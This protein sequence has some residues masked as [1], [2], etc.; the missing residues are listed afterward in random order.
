[1]KKTLVNLLKFAV[2]AGI[3]AWLFYKARQDEHF[4]ELVTGPK[5]WGL[6]LAAAFVAL[7]AVLGTILRWYFLVRALELPFTVKD[8][9]RLGFLGYLL[10]FVSV[11]SVGGDLF[12]AVFVAREHPGRRAEAVATVAIDRIIGLYVMFVLASASLLITGQLQSAGRDVQIIGRTTLLA[13]LAGTVGVVVVLLPGMTNGRFSHW[14]GRIPKVGPIVVRLMGAVRMYRRKLPVLL[15][16]AVI[17]VAVHSL[18]AVAIFLVAR[19]L[20]GNAPTLAEHFVAVPLANLTGLL[21]LPMSGIGAREAAIDYLY[22]H[23]TA[24]GTVQ[25]GKGFVVSLCYR[26]IEIAIAAIGVVYYLA[27][28]REV[29]DVMHESEELAES[30]AV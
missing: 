4:T 14:M 5:H 21:P 12:K 2:S 7:A 25:A 24:P 6:L 27:A 9:F 1:M 3:I 17:S 30:A 15:L 23:L 11:G 20:P 16:A 18:A 19:G 10:N 26:L 22:V 28:R 29:A 13:T 8:A